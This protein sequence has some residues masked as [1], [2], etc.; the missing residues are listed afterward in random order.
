M[1]AWGSGDRTILVSSERKAE[2]RRQVGSAHYP[3]APVERRFAEVFRR[4][5]FSVETIAEP[6][7]LKDGAPRVHVA[8]RSSENL[9][10][11]SGA[12]NVCQFGWEFDVLQDRS[13][14]SE[15][16]LHNQVHMLGL[17]DEIWAPSTYTQQV[18]R[19]HGL[20]QAQLMP[21]PVCEADPKP[22][23]ASQAI[24]DLIGD[25]PLTALGISTELTPIENQRLASRGTVALKHHPAILDRLGGGDGR[26]YLTVCN[27]HD[28]RK[29]LLSVIDGFRM[30]KQPGDL[31]LIKLIITNDGDLEG[32]QD[33][34]FRPLFQG[35]PGAIAD[36]DVVFLN[37]Y[38][39]WPQMEALYSLADVY[40]SATH[41]E[42]LN[43]PLLEAMAFGVAPV[44]TRVT[45]MTDY[46]TPENAVEISTTR[47]AGFLPG[48]AAD[49]ARRPYEVDVASR[50]DIARAIATTRAL[51]SAELAQLGAA[52]RRT[53]AELYSFEAV[54]RRVGERLSPHLDLRLAHAS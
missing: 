50:S 33:I 20:S 11:V 40:L 47:Y 51:G 27:P 1:T 21:T 14:P 25:A 6:Q 26:L 39:D 18:L 49:V 53:V 54:A 42:G 31:L 19:A 48:M 41:C 2:I 4:L 36:P 10:L 30:T 32:A 38:L 3:Y 5:G 28:Q 17:F 35:A 23:L 45:A 8:F 16:I 24:L 43:M 15:P 37:H 34:H 12:F 52:A 13:L 46:L 22:R 29:N 44:A 9:R 7:Q